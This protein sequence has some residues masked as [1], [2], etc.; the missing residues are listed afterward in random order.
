MH[1]CI[2]TAPTKWSGTPD[3][4]VFN[5]FFFSPLA[6]ASRVGSAQGVVE[7]TPTRGHIDFRYREA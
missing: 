3:L 1:E 4:R 2:Q 7:I 5:L 6:E